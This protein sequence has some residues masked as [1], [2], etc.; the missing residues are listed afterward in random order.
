[1]DSNWTDKYLIN[2]DDI[3]EQHRGFFELWNKQCIEANLDDFGQL[4]QIIQ[5]LENYMINHF[6]YEEKLLEEI[7]YEHIAEHKAQHQYFIMRVQEMKQ[8]LEYM[9]PLLFEKTAS[10]MKKWF[11]SHIMQSDKDY[12]KTIKNFGR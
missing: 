2:I 4:G 10:F 12:G 6:T 1:M 3:D 11:L 7:N 5:K 8:E 9:N